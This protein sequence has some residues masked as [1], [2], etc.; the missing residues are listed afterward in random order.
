M[1][2]WTDPV[3]PRFRGTRC[4]VSRGGTR[5]SAQLPKTYSRCPHHPCSTVKR[6]TGDDDRLPQGGTWRACRG[7]ASSVQPPVPRVHTSP[8]TGSLRAWRSG[9]RVMIDLWSCPTERGRPVFLELASRACEAR[10]CC[11]DGHRSDLVGQLAIHP[12]RSGDPAAGRRSA[13]VSRAEPPPA[14]AIRTTAASSDRVPRP[15]GRQHC[16]YLRHEPHQHAAVRAGGQG[17]RVGS[18]RR[19]GYSRRSDGDGSVT[20]LDARNAS[21]P[22]TPPAVCSTPSPLASTSAQCRSTRLRCSSHVAPARCGH[23]MIIRACSAWGQKTAS[24]VAE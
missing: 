13:G 9:R 5:R 16:L 18:A 4:P 22:A 3:R 1:A 23:R 17:N 14:P 12:S 10:H 21:N 20:F 11:T 15:C 6:P 7:C 24:A 19:S 8:V 2:N